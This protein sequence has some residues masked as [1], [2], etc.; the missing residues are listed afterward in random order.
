MN[1][2]E[3]LNLMRFNRELAF[4]LRKDF[5]DLLGELAEKQSVLK[6][7]DQKI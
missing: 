6:E 4:H 7:E 5:D 1:E 3:T 2:V